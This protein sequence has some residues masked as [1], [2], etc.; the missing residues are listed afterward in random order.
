ME[1]LA[2]M[3]EIQNC[4]LGFLD[5]EGEETEQRFRDLESLLI[6]KTNQL[7]KYDL[8][9]VL[10]LISKITKTHYRSS[11]FF[12]KTK[13]IITILKDQIK[14]TFSNSDIF[15]IFKNNKLVLL[16][17]FNEGILLMDENILNFIQKKKKFS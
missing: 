2:K 1:Y 5:E 14:Q 9:S 11:V 10:Y 15:H 13:E 7:D 8:K 17:L 12:D 6:S 16:I 3:G 4:I